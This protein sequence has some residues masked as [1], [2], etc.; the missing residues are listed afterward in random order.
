M[1]DVDADI[2]LQKDIDSFNDYL[3]K[4]DPDNV[5]AS[6]F[7]HVYIPDAVRPIK[8]K[9]ADVGVSGDLINEGSPGLPVVVQKYPKMRAGDVVKVYWDDDQ[10][11]THKVRAGQEDQPLTFNI[12]TEDIATGITELYCSVT[13]AGTEN[14][15]QSPRLDVL[16]RF[17][18]P[19]E[20]A[21]NDDSLAAPLVS[22]DKI[23]LQSKGV[24]VTIPTYTK[25]RRYDRIYLSW[26]G[27]MLEHEVKS[28]EVGKA[29]TINIPDTVVDGA[30]DA[31]LDISYYVVDEVGNESADW[32]ASTVIPNGLAS[33][34]PA[35]FVVVPQTGKSVL[36]LKSGEPGSAGLSVEIDPPAEGF[37]LDAQIHAIW[38]GENAQGKITTVD[39]GTQVV[40]RSSRTLVFDL[41]V[42]HLQ[43]LWGGRGTASYELVQGAQVEHS[44]RTRVN[45]IG[46]P[47]KLPPP[48]LNGISQGYVDA[49]LDPVIVVIPAAA[50]LQANDIVTL[51]WRGTRVDTTLLLKKPDALTISSAQAGKDAVFRFI[52]AKA[53]LPLDG[54]TLDISYTVTRGK[55]QLLS[56]SALLDVG[57]TLETLIPPSLEPDPANAILDPSLAEYAAGVDLVV[58]LPDMI[59]PPFDVEIEWSTS[60]GGAY[61]DTQSVS[62]ANA[63]RIKFQ[64]PRAQLEPGLTQAQDVSVYY[65]ILRPGQ[66]DLISYDL[67]L[68]MGKQPKIDRPLPVVSELKEDKLDPSSLTHGA[69]I[70]IPALAVLAAGDKVVIYWNGDQ[71]NSVTE[72]HDSV[73]RGE[74]GLARTLTVDL[75]YVLASENGEVDLQYEIIRFEHKRP[76]DWSG[77]IKFRVQREALPPAVIAEAVQGNINP[78]DLKGQATVVI[79]AAA[80]LGI[81]DEVT[82]E[83]V[84]LVSNHVDPIPHTVKAGEP[85]QP[86]HVVLP[87]EI[88]RANLN[89]GLKVLYRIKRFANGRVEQSAEQLYSVSHVVSTAPLRV[90]GARYNLDGRADIT[91]P[92]RLTAV[93]ASTSTPIIAEW[94]YSGDTDWASGQTWHDTQPERLLEVRTRANNT[95][96]N[97]ANVQGNSKGFT[98][99]IDTSSPGTYSVQS[100][101]SIAVAP[102]LDDVVDLSVNG[103]A[104]AA[105]RLNGSISC[106]G[107]AASGGTMRPEDIGRRD[108][109][110]VR[111][112]YSAFA[113][114]YGNDPGE[115]RV[116]GWG[117]LNK[118]GRIP[119]NILDLRDIVDV[120][121]SFYAFA[122]LRSNGALVAWGDQSYGAAV[123]PALQAFDDVLEVQGGAYGFLARRVTADG[124]KKV[125]SWGN[126]LGAGH[127]P[128]AISQ[129]DDIES[130]EAH[131]LKTYCLLTSQEQVLA[132]GVPQ[133]GGSIPAEIARLTDVVEVTSTS[134]AFCARRRNGHVVAWGSVG[135][136]G[137]LP[138]DIAKRADVIQVAATSGAFA[139]L[140]ADGSLKC[141]GQAATGANSSALAGQLINVRAIYANYYAFTALTDDGRV[142]TWGDSRYG[143]NSLPA[144]HYLVQ[145]LRAQRK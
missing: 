73:A 11:W 88:V 118:G 80:K 72:V 63:T 143:G 39:L 123:P 43:A 34:L 76:S 102:T 60:S 144:Q 113:A 96:L 110:K 81:G 19:G 35:P 94:R 108:F 59:T 28:T 51:T 130:I 27:H 69:T 36:R 136:G 115:R 64:I 15:E 142:L 83:V 23:D 4:L 85:G 89:Q 104:M 18:Y 56:E 66:P 32:S 67:D 3:K 46:T 140:F 78:F 37:A 68:V 1:S 40:V 107:N 13:R 49:D 77:L 103:T 75:P 135:Y 41:P 82:I 44:K 97:V 45:F 10:V 105:R 62:N 61:F 91:P 134:Y 101:G 25:M 71:A 2:G 121:A 125:F 116:T 90:M 111:S 33:G 131:G 145:K 127:M 22:H 100:W 92:R 99:L 12:P 20:D 5:A 57:D 54:G 129:R 139:A 7:G 132:F 79:A 119:Q 52:A 106:W 8:T 47:V 55:A 38:T 95:V 6:P 133:H 120:A 21:T 29:V 53:L 9:G 109:F 30:S 42:E 48:Q 141:W 128:A 86:L 26:S 31:N 70:T 124:R 87:L 50:K 137:S 14:E 98:A 17:N 112:N 65:R 24:Q 114:L 84:G 122:A 126:E 93:H 138:A 58:P 117:D 74:E 16:V